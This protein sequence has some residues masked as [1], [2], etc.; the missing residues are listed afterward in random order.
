MSE[1]GIPEAAA[2][3]APDGGRSFMERLAGALRLDSA[4][5]DD[6]GA[7]PASLGQAAGVVLMAA[8]ARALSAEGGPF[9]GQGIAFAI[10]VAVLWPIMTVL[11][12]AVGNW[13]GHPAGAGRVLRVMGFAMAPFLLSAVG[14]VPNEWVRIAAAFLST[15][16]LIGA[17]AVG[18]RQSL[19]TTTGRAAFVL[20]VSM[21]TVF[22]VFMLLQYFMS[23]PAA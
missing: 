20:L 6:I 11:T 16:L 2:A 7:D 10:Q 17:F 22:F 15:A 9:G 13:F 5:Y 4:V 14:V 19:Q 23:A 1:A 8:A 18:V 21:L 12:W 3:N